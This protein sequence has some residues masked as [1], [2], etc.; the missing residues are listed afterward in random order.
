MKVNK[1]KQ[2]DTSCLKQNNLI[3]FRVTF[4]ELGH[5]FFI[6]SDMIKKPY[7]QA[8]RTLGSKYDQTMFPTCI[9]KSHAM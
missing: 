7:L 6:W 3:K 4:A 8:N 5:G 9:T 1:N 2:K